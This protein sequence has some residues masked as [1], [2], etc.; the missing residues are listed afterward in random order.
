LLDHGELGRLRTLFEDDEAR[1]AQLKSFFQGEFGADLARWREESATRER[2][3]RRLTSGFHLL[4]PA[5]W[6]PARQGR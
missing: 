6:L 4:C 2:K 1:R 3:A 5:P